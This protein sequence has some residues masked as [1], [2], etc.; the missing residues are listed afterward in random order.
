MFFDNEL[1]TTPLQYIRLCFFVS[2]ELATVIEDDSHTP[3][4]RLRALAISLDV[5]RRPRPSAR[6]IWAHISREVSILGR[7]SQRDRKYALG[8]NVDHEDLET[9]TYRMSDPSLSCIML[10]FISAGV[11]DTILHRFSWRCKWVRNRISV[12]DRGERTPHLSFRPSQ[13][14][15]LFFVIK[16]LLTDIR[17]SP[18]ADHIRS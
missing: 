5:L 6:N 15:L 18:E 10:I 4:V 3:H 7:G 2:P 8:I 9:E 1:G 14:S 17:T 11:V 13:P 12:R 16:S